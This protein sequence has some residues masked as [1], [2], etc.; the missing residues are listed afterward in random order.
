[1]NKKVTYYTDEQLEGLKYAAK[2]IDFGV[3]LTVNTAINE[4]Y[5]AHLALRECGNLYKREVKQL[6]NRAYN[7]AVQRKMLMMGT[8]RNRDFFDAYS[9]KVVDLVEDDVSLLRISIKQ[10]LD[11]N[12]YKDSYVISYIETARTLLDMACVHFEEVVKNTCEDYAQFDYTSAFSEFYPKDVLDVWE[13]MCNILYKCVGDIDLNTKENTTLSNNI[14]R[15]FAN[16]E[17]VDACMKE[18]HR[19]CPDFI[20]NAIVVKD[21]CKC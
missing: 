20:K 15:K 6:A 16:G 2:V 21:G 18:A 3:S 1:M 9:E 8:M 12:K 14:A 11:D 10:T 5:N 13:K 7:L 19:V 4:L 17:Y